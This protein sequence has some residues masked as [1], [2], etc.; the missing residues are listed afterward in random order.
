MVKVSGRRSHLTADKT[1]MER[2]FQ[3]R[4]ASLDH[5]VLYQMSLTFAD[6]LRI[7]RL[8]S[9]HSNQPSYGNSYL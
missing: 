1:V 9:I 2:S 8:D 4:L 7:L 3:E 6:F 5:H